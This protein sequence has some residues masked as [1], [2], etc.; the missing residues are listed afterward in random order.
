MTAF[1][2]GFDLFKRKPDLMLI[3]VWRMKPI[4]NNSASEEKAARAVREAFVDGY[5][6][7]RKQRDEY[8]REKR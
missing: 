6:A 8:E 3:E 1:D 4:N 5:M 7:G 2:E